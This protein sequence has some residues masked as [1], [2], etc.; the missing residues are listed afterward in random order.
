MLDT[1]GRSLHPILA[2]IAN[3]EVY[4]DQTCGVLKLTLHPKGYE[5]RFLPVEGETSTDSGS[6]RCHLREYRRKSLRL[7]RIS[8][9]T[10]GWVCSGEGC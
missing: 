10:Q 2:P 9:H 6:A 8:V 4:N 3:S 1:G 5:G 7:F